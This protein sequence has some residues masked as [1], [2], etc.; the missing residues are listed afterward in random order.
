LPD[1]DHGQSHQQ[2]EHGLVQHGA[3]LDRVLPAQ[4]GLPLHPEGN[5]LGGLVR[6]HARQVVH[7]LGVLLGLEEVFAPDDSRGRDHRVH[8]EAE[9]SLTCSCGFTASTPSELDGHFLRLFTPD[10]LIGRDG[11]THKT[12]PRQ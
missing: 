4:E 5:S 1:H 3:H 10:S 6:V 11:A 12:H 7:R 2:V 8:E 9:P